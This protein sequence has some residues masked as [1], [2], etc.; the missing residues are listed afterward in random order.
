MVCENAFPKFIFFC[1]FTHG[2]FP[3]ARK[4]GKKD[5]APPAKKAKKGSA[6][7]SSAKNASKESQLAPSHAYGRPF[8]G[9][10]K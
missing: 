10:K 1:L 5:K 9:K 8:R 7:R 3:Q 6:K 2:P 4:K